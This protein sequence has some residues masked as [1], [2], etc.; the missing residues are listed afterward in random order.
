MS[1]MSEIKD[2]VEQQGRAWE[3]FKTA[4]DARLEALE[5]KGYAPADLVEK[6]DKINKDLSAQQA[7]ME[8]IAKKASRPQSAAGDGKMTDEEL[9]YKAAL[10]KYL[11]KGVTDGLRDMEAKTLLTNTD[12]DGG[13][14][15]DSEMDRDIDR[16]AETIS[17]LRSVS[18]VRTIGSASFKKYVKTRGVSGGWLEENGT[19][20]ED[21][22]G[23]N[24]QFSQIEIK[25]EKVYA[26]PW[27]SNEMLEDA[28]YDL[29]ADISD[30]AG[31]T[32]A[33]T[34]GASFATGNGVGRPRGITGYTNTA[35]ASVS[36]GEVG[37]IA[38]GAAGAFAS[39][40]P[41]DA[42]VDLQHALKQQYRTGAWFVMSDATL[43][44]V[45]QFKDSSGAYYMWQPDTTAGFGG[46]LLGSPVLVD[47]N[48]PAVAANSYSVAF[49]NFRRGYT[50]VDRRGVAIIRD[51]VTKKGVTKFH[52]TKRV[53]G[54]IT[55][56]EAIKL[57]KMATS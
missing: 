6:V 57:L 13:Y 50:I 48:M 56:F 26:E 9:E 44:T 25:P 16:V 14:V 2:L 46:R 19:S 10:G 28:F 31:I 32:F 18:N 47:D 40:D 36:W 27:V 42:L 12:P 24:M 22:G 54:G 39:S 33:E 55:N 53:G 3:E 35:N 30:E 45:R 37:Y 29:E 34:E 5:S 20:S 4:N 41:A 11:R 23:T 1:D 38:S 21:A 8:E 51:N 43:G 52:V 49:G 15:V 17:T 7:E